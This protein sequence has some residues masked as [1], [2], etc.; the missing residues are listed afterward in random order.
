MTVP[1]TVV[2]PITPYPKVTFGPEFLAL[3]SLSFSLRAPQHE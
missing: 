3:V 2:L 1:E